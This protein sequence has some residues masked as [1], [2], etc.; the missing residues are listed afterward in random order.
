[1]KR[2]DRWK[3]SSSALDKFYFS[4]NLVLVPLFNYGKDSS[5]FGKNYCTVHS[6]KV[7]IDDFQRF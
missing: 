3:S 6:P 2:G 7:V 5:S 4:E 1:M